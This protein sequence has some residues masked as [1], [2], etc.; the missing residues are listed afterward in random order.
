MTG[1][2]G[3]LED[4]RMEDVVNFGKLFKKFPNIKEITMTGTIFEAAQIQ[5]GNPFM[6]LFELGKNL[7]FIEVIGDA[8][9]EP[10]IIRRRDLDGASSAREQANAL[11]KEARFKNQYEAASASMSNKLERQSPGY[12][13]K[14]YKVADASSRLSGKSFSGA[15]ASWSNVKNNFKKN[16]KIKTV[17]WTGALAITGAVGIVFGAAGWIGKKIGSASAKK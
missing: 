3:G 15:S 11:I 14:V 17:A 4:V 9:S 16:K 5:L 13:T 7:N 8:N 6:M 10:V 2:L 12:K 1:L